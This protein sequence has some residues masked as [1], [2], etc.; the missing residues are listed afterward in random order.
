[1][2]FGVRWGLKEIRPEARET[3]K[4]AARRAGMPLGDWLNSVILQQAAQQGLPTP[5]HGDDN[6]PG[7]EVATLHQRLDDLTRHIEM[8]THSGPAAYA[9]RRDRS[10][11]GQFAG[12]P[13]TAAPPLAPAMA[14]PH[15]QLPPGLDYA[16]AEVSARRRALNGEP[17]PAPPQAPMAAPEPAV[18]TSPKFAPAIM[19]AMAAPAPPPLRA[20]L[21]AQDL[22]GLENQ[23]RRITD[24]IETLRK[25]GIEDAINALRDELGEISRALNEAMPRRA[26]ESIEHQ[27]LKLTTRIDEGRQ[28]GVDQRALAGIE[29]GLAE[30]RDALHGLTPAENLVGF[31]EAVT[32]LAHKI[33]QIIAQNDPAT[34]KQL[35]SA[36][37]TLREMVCHIA[38]N[39]TVSQLAAEVQALGAKVE[40]LA[41]A[42]SSSDALIN[43][44]HRVTALANVLTERAQNS[45]AVS[46]QLESLVQALGAKVDQLAQ[47]AGSNDALINLDHRVTALADVL[48]ERAQN[49]GA[50]SPQLESLVQSLANKIEHIQSSR[51]DNVAISHLEDRIVGLVSKLD[52]SESR[53]GQLEAI[54]RGLGDLLVHI[55]D[56]KAKPPAEAPPADAAPAV[57]EL[58]HN[59]ARTQDALESV[60]GTLGIVV[61]RLAMIE[62]GIR[63][64][65]RAQPPAE[66]APAPQFGKL[67][68][69]AVSEAP[70]EPPQQMASEPAGG[71]APPRGHLAADQSRTVDRPAARA[72]LRA[73]TIQRPYRRFGSRPRRRRTNARGR[74]RRQIEFHRRR[75]PRRP[76][77]EPAVAEH[78]GA[79][80][81]AGAG[82]GRSG[83][84]FAARQ[85]HEAR[86]IAV[87]CGEHHCRGGRRLPD[88][89]QRAPPRRRCQERGAQERA[90]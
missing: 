52:A 29:H 7:G 9:P 59:M 85:D 62:K 61:D 57:D 42:A 58:K 53:L 2:K 47:A 37:I 10:D 40:Q 78:I 35:K 44:D 15:V 71:A 60:H 23:L 20:P 81:R 54:E 90:G 32:N 24:Q 89:R 79:A 86:E 26:I 1:M 18:E 50:V 28:A 49:G 5:A 3:A 51:G 14:R 16:V 84:A 82:T 19:A 66:D 64:E 80:R 41:Q 48:T 38:S 13:R 11:P 55:E 63:S 76:G 75:P 36:I 45:G 43:L 31:N 56:M 88:R 17:A 22:S 70:P 8:M 77:S 34:L 33:D 25:P 39:E 30:V 73:T 72:G 74:A 87:H 68:V 12:T 65:G 83:T 67:A 6:V 21:P 27:I 46:P 4:E 69:R